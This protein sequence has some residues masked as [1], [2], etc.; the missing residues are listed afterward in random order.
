MISSRAITVDY[1]TGLYSSL[2][3]STLWVLLL[4]S[5]S[6]DLHPC[7][8]VLGSGYWTRL[9]AGGIVSHSYA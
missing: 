8:F 6:Y 9:L 1:E 3:G 5:D 7:P 2:A 4:L